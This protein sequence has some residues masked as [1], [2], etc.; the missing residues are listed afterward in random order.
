MK[1]F[2]KVDNV[3]YTTT[4]RN[5]KTVYKTPLRRKAA[6]SQSNLV[7]VPYV[8]EQTE[9]VKKITNPKLLTFDWIRPV[10]EP[11]SLSSQPCVSLAM[12]RYILDIYS[13]TDWAEL[14]TMPSIGALSLWGAR[15][16]CRR[17]VSDPVR[18]LLQTGRTRSNTI[19]FPIPEHDCYVGHLLGDMLCFITQLAASFERR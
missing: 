14:I 15:L 5:G 9:L 6:F 19:R 1:T 8:W 7:R 16:L 17:G 4:Y 10:A 13:I 11:L 3:P 18:W 2:E 12:T